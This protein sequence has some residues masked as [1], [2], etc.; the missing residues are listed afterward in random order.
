MHGLKTYLSNFDRWGRLAEA[1]VR[2]T[3]SYAHP[4]DSDIAPNCRNNE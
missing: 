2:R 4:E 3:R 1:T